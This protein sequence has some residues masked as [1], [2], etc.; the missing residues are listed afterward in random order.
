MSGLDALRKKYCLAESPKGQRWAGGIAPYVCTE[1]VGHA[2]H[3]HIARHVQTDEVFAEWPVG[4]EPNAKTA[5]DY[6]MLSVKRS[7]DGDCLAIRNASRGEQDAWVL[8][9][10]EGEI[11]DGVD[12]DTVA[13]WSDMIALSKGT[14]PDYQ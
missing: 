2:G 7:P 11:T 4:E 14:A 8:F 6:R 3:V 10:E 13:D 12:H 1:P 5:A 9:S